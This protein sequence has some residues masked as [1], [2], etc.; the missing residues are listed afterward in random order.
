MEFNDKDLFDRM[1][2]HGLCNIV[3][4]HIVKNKLQ[5]KFILPLDFGSALI[6]L[7]N[8]INYS[9]EETGGA[10]VVTSYYD[11]QSDGRARH[12]EKILSHLD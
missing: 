1:Y 2:K 4:D 8:C 6:C 10:V 3:P 12:I 5:L 9:I 11:N 7:S